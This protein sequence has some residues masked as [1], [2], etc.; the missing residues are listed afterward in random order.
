MLRLLTIVF[1]TLLSSLAQADDLEDA[2]KAWAPGKPWPAHWGLVTHPYKE[3]WNVVLIT[4]INKIYDK[5]EAA[6]TKLKHIP[7]AMKKDA[8][9]EVCMF[10]GGILR[11][12]K[13]CR[14]AV[15]DPELAGS[16]KEGDIVAMF[17]PN[18]G[19]R[20]ISRGPGSD[21]RTTMRIFQKLGVGDDPD[22]WESLLFIH[23][24]TAKGCFDRIDRSLV[25]RLLTRDFGPRLGAGSDSG[26][27]VTQNLY[28][29]VDA[30]NAG[31][32]PDVAVV[33]GKSEVSEPAD[34]VEKQ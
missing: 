9:V 7:Y 17:Y 25:E 8:A 5:D 33:T 2:D 34:E 4:F 19:T 14:D 32:T 10:K 29:A 3:G 24:P 16:L 26:L 23:A 22:C 18:H 15:I 11:L 12:S 20:G 13:L 6:G 28:N 31:A 1:F 30:L 21:A 27:A